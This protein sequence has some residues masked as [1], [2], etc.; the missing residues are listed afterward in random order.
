MVKLLRRVLGSKA[1]VA[2]IV[3]KGIQ[4]VTGIVGYI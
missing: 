2:D 3:L 1:D 4:K